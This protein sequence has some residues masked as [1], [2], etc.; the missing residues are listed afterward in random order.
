VKIIEENNLS[1]VR[2]TKGKLPSLP[3]TAL[4]NLI[5]GKNY[6]LSI[7]FVSPDKSRNLNKK[8]RNKNSPTNVLSFAYEKGNGEIVISLKTARGDA[9]RFNTTYKNFVAHLVIHAMLH[10]KGMQHG[11]TMENKE[12]AVMDKFSLL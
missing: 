7:A 3:F 9:P 6:E 4:K 2:E 5:L 8:Y 1:I 12:K 10:L 11:S